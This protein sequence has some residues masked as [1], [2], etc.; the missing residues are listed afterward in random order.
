MT[1]GKN[2]EHFLVWLSSN[3][4]G[5]VDRAPKELYV[6]VGALGLVDSATKQSA[7]KFKNN[8]DHTGVLQIYRNKTAQQRKLLAYILS[9]RLFR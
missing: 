3:Q 7:R 8:I 5:M 1:F 2:V 4:G 6:A 9:E